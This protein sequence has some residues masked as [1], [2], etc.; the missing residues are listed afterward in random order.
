MNT[1]N[2]DNVTA[3]YDASSND[4]DGVFN[5]MNGGHVNNVIDDTVHVSDTQNVDN[6]TPDCTLHDSNV[7]AGSSSVESHDQLYSQHKADAETMRQEQLDNETLRG[8][9]AYAKHEKS[10]FFVKDNSLYR[11]EKILGQSFCQLC[12]PKPRRAQV[13]QLAHD[14]F[15]SHLGAKRTQERIRG[16]R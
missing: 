2:R 4:S 12:L 10:R 15:G 5:E 6:V 13:L 8:R 9:W 1:E 14:T 16:P 7:D 3:Q 11:L